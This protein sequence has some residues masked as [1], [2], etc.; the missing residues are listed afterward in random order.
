MVSKVGMFLY[1]G[2]LVLTIFLGDLMANAWLDRY[3]FFAYIVSDIKSTVNDLE[4]LMKDQFLI[5]YRNILSLHMHL[6]GDV[7]ESRK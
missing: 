7:R 1:F 6:D 2:R 5:Y 3:L 4:Y